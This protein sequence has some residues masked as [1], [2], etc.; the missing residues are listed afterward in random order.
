M[1]RPRNIPGMIPLIVCLCGSTRFSEAFANA[2]LEETLKGHIVLTV[3]SMT[4]SDVALRGT[5]HSTGKGEPGPS[6]Q[7]K[8]PA[9]RRD[10]GLECRWIYRGVHAL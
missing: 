8:D 10:S 5:N 1:D 7:T 2:N 3:G 4:H 9:G 6:P